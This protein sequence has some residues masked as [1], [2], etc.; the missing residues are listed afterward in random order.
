MKLTPRSFDQMV[1]PK[2]RSRILWGA[3]RIARHLGCSEDFVTG[4]LAEEPGS[5]IRKRGSRW[6]AHEDA[7]MR[8]FG[9]ER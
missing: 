8:W 4:S 2:P 3:K 9:D 1:Q 6:C 7:L 5:P